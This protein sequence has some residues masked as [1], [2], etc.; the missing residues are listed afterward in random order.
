[1]F[2]ELSR[3]IFQKVFP[4]DRITLLKSILTLVHIWRKM[5]LAFWF[6]FKVDYCF[7]VKS[8]D[9]LVRCVIFD[10]WSKLRIFFDRTNMV[11][12]TA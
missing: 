10:W 4:E 8:C 5:V 6:P 3:P 2:N 11:H 9:G 1:M 12:M 7:T